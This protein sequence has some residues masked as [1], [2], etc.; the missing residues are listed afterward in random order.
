M[1]KARY[2]PLCDSDGRMTQNIDELNIDQNQLANDLARD[3][4]DDL[5]RDLQ[6]MSE[7]FFKR[8]TMNNYMYRIKE[9]DPSY[10]EWVLQQFPIRST[11]N[12][13]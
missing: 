6:F 4:D 12:T 10:D 11:D 3:I 7:T 5:V 2:Q 9:I 1:L 8:F 13:H